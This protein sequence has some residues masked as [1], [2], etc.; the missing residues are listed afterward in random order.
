MILK[1][2]MLDE[3]TINV[4]SMFDKPFWLN[5]EC[6]HEFIK[7]LCSVACW[8]TFRKTFHRI[9]RIESGAEQKQTLLFQLRWLVCNLSSPLQ[10]PF[11]Q[12]S[13]PPRFCFFRFRK[14]IFY[15]AN[16]SSHEVRRRRKIHVKVPEFVSEWSRPD[17]A[18]PFQLWVTQWW[19]WWIVLVSSSLHP[20]DLVW[21]ATETRR[22]RAN[23]SIRGHKLTYGPQKRR[24]RAGFYC[25]PSCA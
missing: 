20:S 8:A 16:V 11:P 7:T 24:V 14:Q 4:F 6:T 17:E 25:F 3:S 2:F 12:V 21:Q 22:V 19:S 13:I 10:L 15:S 5:S 9:K 1:L 23:K 18:R